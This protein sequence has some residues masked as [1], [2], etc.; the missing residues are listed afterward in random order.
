M[1][2]LGEQRR[3]WVGTALVA[4]LGTALLLGCVMVF[5]RWLYP[6]LSTGDL[7]RAGVTGKERLDA[8]S[9]R[10]KLQ[11]DVRTTL[12]QG[13]GGAVVLAGAWFTYRQLSHSREQLRVAEQGQITERFTRAVDQL[14]SPQLD[15]RLGGLYALERIARDSPVDRGPTVA[16]ISAYVRVHAARPSDV[17]VKPDLDR[18][19]PWLRN[20]AADLQAALH[21]L[22]RGIVSREGARLDLSLV[23]LRRCHLPD[24]R[25]A[26][27]RLAESLLAGSYLASID[28]SEGDLRE[29][30]LRKAVLTS[31][32]LIGA[33][34]QA[35]DFRGANLA[36]ADLRGAHLEGADLVGAELSSAQLKGATA[37]STTRWPASFD[38]RAAGVQMAIKPESAPGA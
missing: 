20:R 17:A 4:L 32:K 16:I 6:P 33:R 9:D 24:G 18:S 34:L 12:L 30:D 11:N 28:L 25:L 36:G 38:Y 26:R 27:M 37:D 2:I 22:G 19:L 35:A 15:V 21:I 29:A 13:L 31:A 5:P 1:R 3:R 23:D 8:V 10:L 7:D 14:G